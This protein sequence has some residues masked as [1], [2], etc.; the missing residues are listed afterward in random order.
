MTAPLAPLHFP[1]ARFIMQQGLHKLYRPASFSVTQCLAQTFHILL[2]LFIGFMSKQRSDQHTAAY[3]FL[4]LLCDIADTRILMMLYNE[5]NRFRRQ[6]LFLLYLLCKTFQLL[7]CTALHTYG[8]G[9]LGAELCQLQH[10]DVIIQQGM[11]LFL[12]LSGYLLL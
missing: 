10:T 1:A 11:Q 3:R 4:E 9:C 5:Q 2:C 6:P 8:K 12:L 7:P